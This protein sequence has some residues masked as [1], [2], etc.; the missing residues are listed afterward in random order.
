MNYQYFLQHYARP[1]TMWKFKVK[2]ATSNC[3]YVIIADRKYQPVPN[4][5]TLELV[6]LDVKKYAPG[7]KRVF[8]D[9]SA[10]AFFEQILKGNIEE[11]TP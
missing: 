2:R 10:K 1:Y 5:E 9:A 3:K 11:Y 6:L 4:D 8:H 7:E